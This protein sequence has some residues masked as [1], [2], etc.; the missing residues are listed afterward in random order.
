MFQA[1]VSIFAGYWRPSLASRIWILLF[2]L[3]VRLQRWIGFAPAQESAR[4]ENVGERARKT[5]S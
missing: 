1:L 4:T 3:L 2:F 5:A